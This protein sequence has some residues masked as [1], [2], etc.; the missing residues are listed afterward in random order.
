MEDYLIDQEDGM[1]DAA[2]RISEP[3]RSAGPI[4]QL[5]AELRDE[6]MSE[7]PSGR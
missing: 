6:R 1:K 7:Q 3:G 5:G 2:S 4:Y